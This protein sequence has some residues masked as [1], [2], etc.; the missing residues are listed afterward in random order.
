MLSTFTTEHGALIIRTQDIRAIE[1]KEGRCI[2]VWVIEGADIVVQTR[3]IE[4]TAAENYARL[5]AE[6]LELIGAA[7]ERQ[8]RAERGYPMLP[9]PRG[10]KVPQ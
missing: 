1:D 3:R 8:V 4:G 10:G 5:Q 7:H 2:V 9:V 6:E